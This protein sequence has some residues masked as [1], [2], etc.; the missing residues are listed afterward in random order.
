MIERAVIVEAVE[1]AMHAFGVGRLDIAFEAL[2]GL[3]HV[4]RASNNSSDA[5]EG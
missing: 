4:V 2:R 1:R 5:R 3:L